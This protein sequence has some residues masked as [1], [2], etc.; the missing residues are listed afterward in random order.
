MEMVVMLGVVYSMESLSFLKFLISHG[1]V[2]DV[3]KLLS[4]AL[5]SAVCRIASY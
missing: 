5:A 1:Y 3:A 4:A 2:V